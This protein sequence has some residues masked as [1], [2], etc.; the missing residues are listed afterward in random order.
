MLKSKRNVAPG[1]FLFTLDAGP[2]LPEPSPG[3]FVSVAAPPELTLRRPFS[4]AGARGPGIIELLVEVRGR[5]T[6]ALAESPEG[7][8]LDVFGP[9]GTGFGYPPRGGTAVLVAGGIGVAGLRMLAEKLAREARPALILVGAR[10]RGRLL[11]DL[12]PSS[13]KQGARLEVATDDGSEGFHGPVTGLLETRL[14]GL[15][16]STRVYCCGPKAMIRETARLAAG[17]G[18]ACEALLEEVM[19]CGVGAC[20]G[21]VVETREGYRA[22]CSDGPVFDAADLVFE[23]EPRG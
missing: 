16:D 5:A 3:Q 18:L 21:C 12:L 13:Q 1:S 4:V 23:G 20:R 15:D 22:V 10:S 6:R 14:D 11:T 8:H 19:A 9:L 2:D 7:S 17:H